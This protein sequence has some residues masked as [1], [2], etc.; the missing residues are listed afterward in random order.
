M[1]YD[2]FPEVPQTPRLP[3]NPYAIRDSPDL[4]SLG[5]FGQ[6]ATPSG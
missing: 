6:L 5:W 4:F 1:S 3:P 2:S